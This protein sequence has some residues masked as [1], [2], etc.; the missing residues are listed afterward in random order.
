SRVSGGSSSGSA[1]AVALG[2]VSFALGTD[3]A[4]SG[5]V[6]PAFN[7]L[8]RPEAARGGV[9]CRG[10]GPARPRPGCISLLGERIADAAS[11]LGVAAGFDARDPWS[12]RAVAPL[13]PRTGRIGVPLPDQAEPEEPEAAAAW[14]VA[15]GRAGEQW[16]LHPVDVSPL[17]EAAP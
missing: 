2:L 6:P 14:A 1:L 5:R 4:G 11:V 16:M 9:S 7:R 17:L 12:R 15:R 8:I 13:S 3:T 10:G